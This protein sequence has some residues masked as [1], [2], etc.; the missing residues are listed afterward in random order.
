M[1]QGFDLM[2][3]AQLE[4]FSHDHPGGDT[5]NHFGR[6]CFREACDIH[7][8]PTSILF[9]RAS[10]LRS[11]LRKTLYS[12]PAKTAQAPSAFRLSGFAPPTRF[13]EVHEYEKDIDQL[14]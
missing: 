8:L 10:T 4:D 3:N 2:F 9:S 7:A 12:K 6:S 1:Q 13:C 5:G 14:W 11:K